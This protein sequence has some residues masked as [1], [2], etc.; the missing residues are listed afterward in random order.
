MP[1]P[2]KLLMSLSKA[3]SY[4]LMHLILLILAGFIRPNCNLIMQLSSFPLMQ[5]IIKQSAFEWE[6]L[7]FSLQ[8]FKKTFSKREADTKCGNAA[9]TYLPVEIKHLSHSNG[10]KRNLKRLAQTQG[11]AIM[12]TDVKLGDSVSPYYHMI[13]SFS[14]IIKMPMWWSPNQYILFF[15]LMRLTSVI[16][17]KVTIRIFQ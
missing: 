10:Y 6:Y 13:F 11:S 1:K 12:P 3:L 16:S 15:I 2:V 4:F 17:P 8:R 7:C 9:P 5:T 14:K